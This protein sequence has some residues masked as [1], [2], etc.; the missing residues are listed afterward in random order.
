MGMTISELPTRGD[1]LL[2]TS[3][4][5]AVGAEI[6][7]IVFLTGFLFWHADPRG[8][9]ME[10]VGVGAAFVLI[11]LPFTLPALILARKGRW[12]VLAAV[13][14]AAGAV[15]YFTLWLELLDELHLPS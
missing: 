15:A 3:V 11:F 6:G 13:L 4:L 12:L 10:M 7:F 1:R 8:D 5:F 9:G 14:A 2:R